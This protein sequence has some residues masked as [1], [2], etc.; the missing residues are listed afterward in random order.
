MNLKKTIN[1]ERVFIM[2]KIEGTTMYS[3]K[4]PPKEGGEGN[5]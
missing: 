4:I 2:K 3:Y 1:H 5:G